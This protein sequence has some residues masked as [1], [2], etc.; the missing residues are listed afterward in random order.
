MLPASKTVSKKNLHEEHESAKQN[1]S[2]ASSAQVPEC[3]SALRVP[4][5]PTA[6]MSIYPIALSVRVP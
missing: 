1:A 4:E 6:W 5:C 3:P 2:S